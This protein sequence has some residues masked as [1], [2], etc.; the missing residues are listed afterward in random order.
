MA[1]TGTPR[2]R[3]SQSELWYASAGVSVS[4]ER[5]PLSEVQSSA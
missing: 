5:M 3:K 4:E 2:A 1:C